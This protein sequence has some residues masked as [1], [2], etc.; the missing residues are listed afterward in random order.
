MPV[1]RGSLGLFRAAQ[2]MAIINGKD[3]A[4]VDQIKFLAEKVLAHRLIV[5]KE[6]Q[7]RGTTVG[8]VVQ[9]ILTQNLPA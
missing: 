2:A 5:R 4:S 8:A 9:E 3:S 1:P 6:E 7:F